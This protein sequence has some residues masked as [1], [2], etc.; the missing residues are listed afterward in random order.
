N[1]KKIGIKDIVGD[2]V[3]RI[4][5]RVVGDPDRY[6]TDNQLVC[7][8]VSTLNR[9]FNFRVAFQ[10][11]NLF[12][13]YPAGSEFALHLN[14]Q[15]IGNAGAR[16]IVK[17]GLAIEID[18]H[19]VEQ[20]RRSRKVQRLHR[21]GQFNILIF[22]APEPAIIC[23]SDFSGSDFSTCATRRREIT[24]YFNQCSDHNMVDR[25]IAWIT[26][27]KAAANPLSTDPESVQIYFLNSPFK[28]QREIGTR[29]YRT[30]ITC[31]VAIAG[32]PGTDTH[33][34]AIGQFAIADANHGSI[35]KTDSLSQQPEAAGGVIGSIGQNHIRYWAAEGIIV[36]QP[37]GFTGVVRPPDTL[38]PQNHAFLKIVLTRDVIITVYASIRYVPG[39]KLHPI[40][41]HTPEPGHRADTGAGATNAAIGNTDAAT[42]ASATG[43]E[44]AK[45]Q[46]NGG[47]FEQVMAGD[48]SGHCLLLQAIRAG[49]LSSGIAV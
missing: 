28:L 6:A 39:L 25:E 33:R 15:A 21:P 31:P 36:F 48:A 3:I 43:A 42:T 16:E 45:G 38:D 24:F 9:R 20:E 37:L 1:L 23:E 30:D 27:I 7:R 17:L 41:K 49:T 12:R 47:E 34:H 46:G 4:D 2:I 5:Q 44:D 13:V 32:S 26:D 11:L 14:Q 19:T 29:R 35:I 18:R 8:R 22:L 10:Q 40:H